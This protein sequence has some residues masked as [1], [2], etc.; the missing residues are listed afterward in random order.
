MNGKKLIKELL[1]E[2]YRQNFRVRF[3]SK[4]YVM[5]PPNKTKSVI[6]ISASPS[7]NNAVRAIESDLKKV[8]FIKK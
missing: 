1:K 3:N 7:D 4:H 5:Y 8:G 6:T 2:L